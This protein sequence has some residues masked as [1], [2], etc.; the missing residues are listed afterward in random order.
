MTKPATTLALTEICDPVSD[1][2]TTVESAGA[3]WAWCG[4]LAI[5]LALPG[6]SAGQIVEQS[7]EGFGTYCEPE[8]N[9]GFVRV[10]SAVARR[11]STAVEHRVTATFPR[12]AELDDCSFHDYD[13]DRTYWYGMSLLLD[14]EGFASGDFQQYVGQWRF[15]NLPQGGPVPNCEMF[16][17]CGGG[18]IYGGSGHHLLVQ[19][20]RWVITLAV[21]DPNCGSCEAL[22]H[23]EF[24][25]GPAE[26]DV[27]TDWV[28]RMDFSHETDGAV[29][30]WRAVDGG[31]YEQVAR[32]RGRT[33]LEFYQARSAQRTGGVLDGRVMAPNHTVGLYAANDAGARAMFSDEIRVYQEEAGADGFARV[34][35]DGV[36]RPAETAFG[37]QAW[38]PEGFGTYV[39]SFDLIAEVTPRGSFDGLATLGIADDELANEV[40]DLSVVLAYEPAG[41]L[42]ALDGDTYR[43]EVPVDYVPGTPQSLVFRLAPASG[44]Y[45]AGL[46]E[47]V[48][49]TTWFAR[50]YGVNAAYRGGDSVAYVVQNTPLGSAFDIEAVL[51]QYR[52]GPQT[53]SEIALGNVPGAGFSVSFLLEPDGVNFDTATVA[54]VAGADT[55][56]RLSLGETLALANVESGAVTPLDVSFNRRQARSVKLVIEPAAGTFDLLLGTGEDQSRA[57]A[58]GL[59]LNSVP[60]SEDDLSLTFAT[61][62]G[63]CL[64]VTE[65]TLTDL[66]LDVDCATIEAWNALS[67]PVRSGR[68]E[69]QTTLRIGERAAAPAYYGIGTVAEPRSRDDLSMYIAVDPDGGIRVRDGDSLRTVENFYLVPGERYSAV[70]SVDGLARR[71]GLTLTDSRGELVRIATFAQLN[72]TR[73][74]RDNA[75]RYVGFGGAGDASCLEVSAPRLDPCGPLPWRS[76]RLPETADGSHELTFD[77]EADGGTFERGVIAFSSAEVPTSTSTY[78]SVIVGESGLIEATDGPDTTAAASFFYSIGNRYGASWSTD[79]PAGTHRFAV[80]EFGR[81]TVIGE[82]YEA[83]PNWDGTAPTHLAY[84]TFGDGCLEVEEVIEGITCGP[85]NWSSAPLRA[86]I[87]TQ[88][89]VTVTLTPEGNNFRDAVWGLSHTA[90][91]LDFSSLA[92]LIQFHTDNTIRVRD[93][94]EYRADTRLPYTYGGSYTLTLE[95]DVRAERYSVSFERDGDR[96]YLARDYRFRS[97]WTGTGA[98]THAAQRTVIAGCLSAAS[99]DFVSAVGERSGEAPEIRY[100]GEGRFEV[101]PVGPLVGGE[102]FLYDAAGRLLDDAAVRQGRFELRVPSAPGIFFVELRDSRGQRSVIRVAVP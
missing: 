39:E 54:L 72:A 11:G 13:P 91:P 45:S 42:L 46:I 24:D 64:A 5:F 70:W 36:E 12:R 35:V 8:T 98:L 77:L 16:R 3:L 32:Y 85:E 55:V 31:D 74:D 26:V 76:V 7:R 33:W 27:W 43:S 57:F 19:N 71:Y 97:D 56:L 9:N 100:R 83:N 53:I 28:F 96:I 44:T 80:E 84:R 49:D 88:A 38:L 21:Q 73:N 67:F 60:T 89:E 14:G 29:D 10:T 48:G 93:G 99:G 92:V 50:D 63:G 47:G 95:V 18:E 22:D 17:E 79:V 20:G 87:Q 2:S 41:T 68:F 66:G 40:A 52:C 78:A 101:S 58:R 6:V 1:S 15:S 34:S 51:P 23:V 62:G 86:A 61:G 81:S 25:L 30:V 94:G 4:T 102:A 65:A 82:D 75:Y 37:P 69:V 59:S 90:N